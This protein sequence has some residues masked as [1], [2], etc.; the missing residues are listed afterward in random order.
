M[1]CQTEYYYN[2]PICLEDKKNGIKCIVCKNTH[3]CSDCMLSL[4]EE[5]Y[6]DKCPVCRQ[7]NWKNIKKN[8]IVPVGKSV[9]DIQDFETEENDIIHSK[10]CNYCITTY[11]TIKYIFNIIFI[12]FFLYSIGLGTIFF[13][14]PEINMKKNYYVY[15]LPFVVSLIWMLIIMSPCCCGRFLYNLYCVKIE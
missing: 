2:C 13:T 15:W 14:C 4:C 11:Y 7:E 10:I 9:D 1:L 12:I 6:C 3:I 8:K 5:G